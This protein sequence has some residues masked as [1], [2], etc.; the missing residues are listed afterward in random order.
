MSK[1]IDAL[2]QARHINTIL[3]GLL[4]GAL[5][6]AAFAMYGWKTSTKEIKVHIPPDLRTG[7]TVVAGDNVPVPEP[8]IYMFAHYIWQ[9]INR[10][11]KDGA[12]DYGDRIHAM[13]NFVT[14]ACREQLIADMNSRANAGELLKRTR[15]LQEI[16]GLGYS[17]QRV[18]VLGGNSWQV[19]LDAQVDETQ[20]GIPVKDAYIR[21]PIRVVSFQVDHEINPWGLA[22]DCFGGERP[23]RLDAQSVVVAQKER[24]VTAVRSEA[25]Q[26][27]TPRANAPAAVADKLN[28]PGGAS[29][30]LAP[31]TLP[32]P[33]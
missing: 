19:L 10:W 14:P 15:S 3:A 9:Q 27:I 20:A 25:T 26:H 23:A 13:Q 5:G 33:Q 12:T 30:P 18:K 4:A 28:S 24:G 17:I 8:N 31:T 6:V 2:A 22:L 29:G 32:T 11:P 1:F 7:A 16:P 21:Y